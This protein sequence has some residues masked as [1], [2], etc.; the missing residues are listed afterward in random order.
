[1]RKYLLGTSLV[2]GPVLFMLIFPIAHNLCYTFF[3]GEWNHRVYGFEKLGITDDRQPLP[4]MKP[5]EWGK[6]GDYVPKE[7]PIKEAIFSCIF[8]GQIVFG[9]IIAIRIGIILAKRFRL[10]Q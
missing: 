10:L 6:Q 9:I 1:M 4:Y 2:L 3:F 7:H 8:W 5:L